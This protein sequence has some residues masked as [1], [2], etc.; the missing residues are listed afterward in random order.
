MITLSLTGKSVKEENYRLGLIA[1]DDLL[2]LKVQ[3]SSEKK[4]EILTLA[5]KTLTTLFVILSS[6]TNT[7]DAINFC[8]QCIGQGARSNVKKQQE[9]SKRKVLNILKKGVSDKR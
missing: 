9:R 3:K 1:L 8:N 2:M 6:T 7:K 4:V 5:W